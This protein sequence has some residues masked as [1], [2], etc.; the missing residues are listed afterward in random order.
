MRYILI[1]ITSLILTGCFTIGYSFRGGMIPG[2]TFNIESFTN[3][4]SIINPNLAIVFQDALQERF[5]NESNLK[6][7]DKEQKENHV[8]FSGTIKKYNISPVQGTGNET[9]AL[10]RLT[11]SVNVLYNNSREPS[12][13]FEKDFTSFDDFESSQDF[14]SVEEE[15]MKTIS[16]KLV[17][18]V[19]NQT[20]VDW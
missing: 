19:Y 16:E 12:L 14:S 1:L 13:N 6:Y 5:T 11:I 9:V 15:L 2:E 10:N 20:I 3:Q 7:T 8:K 17:A 18:L 4:A